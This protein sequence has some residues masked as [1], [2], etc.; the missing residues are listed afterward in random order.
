MFTDVRLVFQN[1][2]GRF[3]ASL[4]CVNINIYFDIAEIRFFTIRKII[5]KVNNI[6]PGVLFA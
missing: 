2:T 3:L 5:G 1:I 4:F 6:K